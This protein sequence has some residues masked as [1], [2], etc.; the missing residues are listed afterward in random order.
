[1][2]PCLGGIDLQSR[3]IAN[4]RDAVKRLRVT[5]GYGS[6]Q[7][8]PSEAPSAAPERLVHPAPAKDTCPLN[9]EPAYLTQRLD[10]ERINQKSQLRVYPTCERGR[11]IIIFMKE[12]GEP[13]E[14]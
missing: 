11:E 10:H 9:R 8:N 2:F 13:N 7:Q 3:Q 12:N 1:M 4:L 6:E 14:L 5:G